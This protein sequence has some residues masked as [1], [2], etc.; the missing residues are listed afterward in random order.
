MYLFLFLDGPIDR[1]SIL[2]RVI[3][4]TQKMV[5]NAALLNTRQYQGQ[6]GAIQGKE[7]RPLLHFG[8][9]AIEK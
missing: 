6:S 2:G 1:G 9:V 5:L 3:P 4:K 7:W 8:E